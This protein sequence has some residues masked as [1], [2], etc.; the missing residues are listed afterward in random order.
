MK[1]VLLFLMLLFSLLKTNL[2]STGVS[3]KP[4]TENTKQ[5]IFKKTWSGVNSTCSNIWEYD[6]RKSAASNVHAAAY[7]EAS[8]N[9]EYKRAI[10]EF[11]LSLKEALLAPRIW[12]LLLIEAG[13]LYSLRSRKTYDDYDYDW[14]YK[15][16]KGDRFLD[17]ATRSAHLRLLGLSDNASKPEIRRVCRDL[18]KQCHPESTIKGA[19]PDVDKM[20]KISNACSDLKKY[21]QLER[22]VFVENKGF[23]G[24]K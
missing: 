9:K 24:Q 10:K 19:T 21:N 20:M 17:E 5:N 16:D 22:P 18:M 2:Y 11:G 3:I 1:K 12:I 8:K 7:R 6:K 23:L 15:E 4:V 14:E 13:I